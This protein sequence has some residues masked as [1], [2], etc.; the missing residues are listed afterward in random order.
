MALTGRRTKI[1]NPNQ[2]SVQ[3]CVTR[4]AQGVTECTGRWAR[5]GGGGGKVKEKKKIREKALLGSGGLA[6][7]TLSI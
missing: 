1:E 6:P 3:Q 5:E 2:R 7:D 4:R